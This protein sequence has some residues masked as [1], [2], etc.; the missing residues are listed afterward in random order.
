MTLTQFFEQQ[1]LL[2]SKTSGPTKSNQ[3]SLLPS[4]PSKTSGPTKSNQRKFCQQFDM[5][6]KQSKT[7]KKLVKKI[8]PKCRQKYF[9]YHYDCKKLSYK[10]K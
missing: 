9:L 10:W 6:Q 7:V 3:Q 5:V 1:S 2:P 4:K 8:C